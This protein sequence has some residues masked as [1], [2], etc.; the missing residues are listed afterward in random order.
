VPEAGE[1]QHV[2][3]QPE[4]DRHDRHDRHDGD[5]W[6]LARLLAA[7]FMLT[8]PR[9]RRCSRQRSHRDDWHRDWDDPDDRQCSC[10]GLME[11]DEFMHRAARR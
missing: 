2:S 8:T 10:S 3:G 4:H 6:R 5:G 1:R 7:Q 9:S 11:A